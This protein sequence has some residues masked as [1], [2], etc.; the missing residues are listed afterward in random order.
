VTVLALGD[1]VYENGTSAEFVNCYDKVWGGLRERTR[2]APGNHHY[3][4]YLPVRRRNAAP[5][6]GYFGS[7]AGPLGKGFYSFDLGAWHI[8]SP[9]GA[10]KA[11]PAPC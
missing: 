8:V 11:F 6:F 1:L 10:R 3:G 9:N 7:N 2:P 4:I 5:Y